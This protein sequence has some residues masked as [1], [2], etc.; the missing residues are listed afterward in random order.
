MLRSIFVNFQWITDYEFHGT[1][2][3]LVCQARK[4]L[5]WQEQNTR[6]AQAGGQRGMALRHVPAGR[7]KLFLFHIFQK[8]NMEKGGT[9]VVQKC[10]VAFS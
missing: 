5:G 3:R 9:E 1:T 10:I 8:E 4:E 6:P 7:A 2:V